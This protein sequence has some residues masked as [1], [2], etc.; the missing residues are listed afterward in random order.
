[1]SCIKSKW[2]SRKSAV[3]VR[4][5]YPQFSS[6][7]KRWKKMQTFMNIFMNKK[8]FKIEIEFF[9]G[10]FV[11]IYTH[12]FFLLLTTLGL[13]LICTEVIISSCKS[14]IHIGMTDPNI[15]NFL[16]CPVIYSTCIWTWAICRDISTSLDFV[17]IYQHI[18]KMLL[19]YIYQHI[20]VEIYQHLL[21]ESRL[22]HP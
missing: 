4:S 18:N 5:D 22:P 7:M 12:Y 11:Y 13:K 19:R 10:K 17:E 14:T 3:F 15:L 9:H 6:L 20:N 16:S 2:T 21:S 1:M 8:H